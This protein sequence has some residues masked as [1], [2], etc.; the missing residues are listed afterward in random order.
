MMTR[1]QKKEVDIAQNAY[2]LAVSTYQD[3]QLE[4]ENGYAK[5]KQD[6]ETAKANYNRTLAL[7]QGGSASRW[8]LKQ[9]LIP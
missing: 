6:F 4:A 5:A 8:S 3:K 7:Y 9:L 1:T 2:D